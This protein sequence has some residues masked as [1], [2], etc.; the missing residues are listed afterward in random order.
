MKDAPS[1]SI[2][3]GGPKHTH[4]QRNKTKNKMYVKA[5]SE[6]GG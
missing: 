4:T 3:D 2:E 1:G 6:K 5:A